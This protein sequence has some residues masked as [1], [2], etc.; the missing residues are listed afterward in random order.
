MLTIL[1]PVHGGHE[2]I[3]LPEVIELQTFV[4][5][6]D[7]R[8]IRRAALLLR[9]SPAAVGKRLDN[10][11]AV[12]GCTLLERGPRGIRPTAAGAS[13]Y[14][15]ARRILADAFGLLDVAATGTRSS[16]TA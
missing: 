8:S 16:G 5:A 14:P 7:E 4:T 9:L 2:P 13:F 12:V 6:S 1:S 10:L 11:E 3:R 15:R